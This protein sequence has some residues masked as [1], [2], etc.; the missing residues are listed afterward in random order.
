MPYFLTI[1]QLLSQS[2]FGSYNPSETPFVSY[3]CIVCSH[4]GWHF[5]RGLDRSFVRTFG[6]KFELCC[7]ST[8][9]EKLTNGTQD[10]KCIMWSAINS[11]MLDGKADS[12]SH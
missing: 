4:T 5:D 1:I 8:Y 11:R 7:T 2:S 12:C 6:E 9:S 10:I 3:C